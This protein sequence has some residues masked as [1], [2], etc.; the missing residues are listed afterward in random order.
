L[1]ELRQHLSVTGDY[2]LAYVD[3]QGQPIFLSGIEYVEE[4]VDFKKDKTLVRR[5]N[6]VI[7]N[8]IIYFSEVP[9]I[10]QLKN[11]YNF[12]NVIVVL[13]RKDYADFLTISNLDIFRFYLR[14][15]EQSLTINDRG[16]IWNTD[17]GFTAHI[18]QINSW[19]Y[20]IN[21]LEEITSHYNRHL[22]ILSIRT[23]WLEVLKN[24]PP[25]L[26]M[27]SDTVVFFKEQIIAFLSSDDPI[28]LLN[29][30]ATFTPYLT[31][32][33]LTPADRIALATIKD[34]FC[35][36]PTVTPNIVIGDLDQTLLIK[37]HTK[38]LIAKD[39]LNVIVDTL[40]Q[41]TPICPLL[42]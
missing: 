17:F 8:N 10:E 39:Q 13:N 24:K 42:L 15:N 28:D 20:F 14:R 40:L 11:S 37:V 4:L 7:D 38:Q 41:E 29:P 2:I 22:L 23:R 27:P 19:T 12:F 36:L 34:D 32:H 25:Q 3:R 30:L 1:S 31:I 6:F 9:N 18:T 33:K 35:K 5:P 16:F 26:N 21:N